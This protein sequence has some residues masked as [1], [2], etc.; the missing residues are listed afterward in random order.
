MC[1]INDAKWATFNNTDL[2]TSLDVE[3]FSIIDVRIK[4]PDNP[5]NLV[6][7]KLI[8]YSID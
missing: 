1:I 5:A 6:S 3:G 7:A 2:L 4:N 8:T